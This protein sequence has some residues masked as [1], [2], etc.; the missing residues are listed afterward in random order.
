MVTCFYVWDDLNL[1]T[2]FTGFVGNDG[3]DTV[4]GGFVV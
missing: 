2:K 3:T 1:R 4:H